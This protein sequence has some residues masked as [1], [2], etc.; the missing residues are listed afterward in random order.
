[1]V[2][3]YFCEHRLRCTKWTWYIQDNE[4]VCFRLISRCRF[5]SLKLDIIPASPSNLQPNM[6]QPPTTPQTT[7][8]LRGPSPFPVG[9]I[10]H[11]EAMIAQPTPPF[12]FA[13]LPN[14]PFSHGQSNPAPPITHADLNPNFASNNP[15]SS[16]A[17]PS[18]PTLSTNPNPSLTTSRLLSNPQPQPQPHPHLLNILGLGAKQIFHCTGT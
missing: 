6:S 1:M 4:M 14:A 7:R 17:S 15:Y 13:N 16:V 11:H 9:P 2:F 8:N 5:R 3:G 10:N 12:T 18:S